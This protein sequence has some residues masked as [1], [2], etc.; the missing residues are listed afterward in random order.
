MLNMAPL[1]KDLT[2]PDNS[3]NIIRGLETLMRADYSIGLDGSGNPL[4]FGAG[5]WAVLSATG[6]L[7]LATATAV[8][9]TFPVWAGNSSDRSDVHATGM[10]TILLGGRFIYQTNLFDTT[11]TYLAGSPITVKVVGANDRVPTLA[12]GTDIVL[13]RVITPPVNGIITLEVVRN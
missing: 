6:T 8:A 10:A 5:Q 9:N 1:T 13:G 7:T 11:A 2:K 12:T 3:M 4:V